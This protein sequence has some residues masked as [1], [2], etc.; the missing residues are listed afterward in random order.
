MVRHL[1]QYI[2]V[3]KTSNMCTSFFFT[4]DAA[5]SSFN[6]SRC[7][8]SGV[9]STETL[10]FTCNL[11]EV[12]LLRVV[13]PTGDQEIISVGDSTADVVLPAGFIA[14]FLDII[15]IN[16]YR[17]NI[18]LTL[19]VAN[20]SLLEASN[21]T[22]DDTTQTRKTMA[23]CPLRSKLITDC[24]SEVRTDCPTYLPCLSRTLVQYLSKIE[25][26]SYYLYTAIITAG[27]WTTY[28]YTCKH[29]VCC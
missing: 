19:S 11:N 25:L 27:C 28:I 3:H 10:F 4:T 29:F 26:L 14:L 18:T 8:S 22:C 24:K 21:I 23:G 6:D 20:A 16:S 7:A 1:T 2:L 12:V 15:E 9:C 13:F 5:Q 17:R